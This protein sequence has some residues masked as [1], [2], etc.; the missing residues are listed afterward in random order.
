MDSMQ[1]VPPMAS[2]PTPRA[3]RMSIQAKQDAIRKNMSI[4]RS[5]AALMHRKKETSVATRSFSN[6]VLTSIHSPALAPA[7]LD[8]PVIPLDAVRS[9]V[10]TRFWIV[11][12]ITDGEDGW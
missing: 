2:F 6:C 12:S 9:V 10:M 3:S 1:D 7:V 8:Q 4:Q 11:V 5:I